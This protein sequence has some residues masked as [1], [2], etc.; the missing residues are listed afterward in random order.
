M[1]TRKP[2]TR[3]RS[4]RKEPV[5]SKHVFALVIEGPILQDAFLD[6]LYE[7]GCS[8]ALFGTVDEVGY[9]DFTRLGPTFT[10]A[11][12]SAIRDVESVE[13][14]RVVRIEPDDLLTMS[15]I[16]GR[17]GRS[18]ESVR[19]LISGRRGPGAFPAPV[20]HLPS[21]SRLWRWSDVAAWMGTLPSKELERSR[22]I[23][24]VNAALELRRQQ[25]DLGE[26]ERELVD[27]LTG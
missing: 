21:R 11:I 19:L 17:L 7:A 22:V 6:A 24:A 20:S 26:R 9:G 2:L 16:A 14:L 27:A 12:A 4:V 25:P 8:D 5:R 1:P 23:A 13:G 10:D 18:R 15:E 3:K